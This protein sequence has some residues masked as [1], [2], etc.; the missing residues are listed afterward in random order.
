MAPG[1]A[2]IAAVAIAWNKFITQT[3]KA[4]QLATQSAW[5]DFF[6]QQIASGNSAAGVLSE[7]QAA[8]ARVEQQLADAGAL[9][10]YIAHRTS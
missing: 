4:G 9:R 10:I 1:A 2:A 6:S 7:Y 5:G 8:Q 3:N